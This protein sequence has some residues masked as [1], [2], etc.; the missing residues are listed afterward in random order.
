M[1]YSAAHRR[2][3]AARFIG[4][5]H[6]QLLS[7]ID[8]DVPIYLEYENGTREP[9]ALFEVAIDTRQTFK[10]ATVTKKLALLA[11]IP[12]YTVLY[13]L[14]NT[15]NPANRSWRDISQYRVKQIAP[16]EWK[17]WQIYSPKEYFEFLLHLRKTRAARLDTASDGSNG[18][19]KNCRLCHRRVPV[20]MLR[21]GEC[22]DGCES[23]LPLD[24]KTPARRDDHAR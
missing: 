22:L 20:T 6:A 5:E 19:L 14:A 21:M 2:L 8:V 15:Y 7:M 24:W 10:T 9:L 16:I 23:G 11:G 12:A 18:Q 1:A 13:T 17:E 3:S 4:I